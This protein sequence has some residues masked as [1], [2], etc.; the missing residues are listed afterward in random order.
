[1]GHTQTFI[2]GKKAPSVTD[3]TSVLSP[4]GKVEALMNWAAKHSTLKAKLVVDP[5]FDLANVSDKMLEYARLSR[6]TFW[7]N[8]EQLQETARREGCEFHELIEDHFNGKES[9]L[10]PLLA[11]W[12]E[13]NSFAPVKWETK[14]ISKQFGYGGTFDCVGFHNGVLSVDDW[15]K[16]NKLYIT[17]LLQLVGYAQAYWETFGERIYR[18][19]LVRFY[20]TS[21]EAKR[22]QKLDKGN[23]RFLYTFEG[24]CMRIEEVVYENLMSYF[25]YFEM[26]LKLHNFFEG[27]RY[28]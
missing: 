28:A 1:M 12:G 20:E 23:G 3:I 13:A 5:E 9:F 4:N 2:D 21:T 6:D 22:Y 26:A 7:F 15:K 17:Y 10:S 14:V 18:G 11:Q 8:H 16:A 25:P 24:S 19:V 27:K